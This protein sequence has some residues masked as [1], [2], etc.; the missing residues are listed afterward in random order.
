MDRKLFRNYFYNILYQLVK[1]VLPLVLLPYTMKH[2]TAPYLG[3]SDFAGSIMLYQTRRLNGSSEDLKEV[4]DSLQNFLNDLTPYHKEILPLY[5][6]YTKAQILE[7]LRDEALISPSR[8]R[9]AYEGLKRR[10]LS[11]YVPH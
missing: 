5:R 6:R 10:M 3:I 11:E 8:S 9:S 1:I 4:L 7:R 2:L